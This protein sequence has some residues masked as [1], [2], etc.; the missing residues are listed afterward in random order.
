[1]NNLDCEA[2]AS[3]VVAGGGVLGLGAIMVRKL[4]GYGPIIVI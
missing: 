2:G 4:R 1:M 3:L